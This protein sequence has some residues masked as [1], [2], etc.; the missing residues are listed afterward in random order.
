MKKTSFVVRLQARCHPPTSLVAE[1]WVKSFISYTT[2]HW[3]ERSLE[4]PSGPD[5]VLTEAGPSGVGPGFSLAHLLSGL[6]LRWGT[7]QTWPRGQTQGLE[8]H[9]D[10][11]CG[12]GLEDFRWWLLRALAASSD[13]V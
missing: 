9:V 2:I 1:M 4:R 7:P 13:E 6:M 12:G 11:P 3:K 8:S 5:G 10:H